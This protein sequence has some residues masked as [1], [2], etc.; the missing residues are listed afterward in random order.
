[1]KR[2][3][4]LALFLAITA[5][6]AGGMLSV[7]DNLTK[8]KI[9]E[10]SLAKELIYLEEIFP[11]AEFEQKTGDVAGV[12]GIL[13]LFEAKGEGFVYKVKSNGYGGGI[14]FLVGF[15][16]DQKIA[17]L[18]IISHG[19]TPGIGDVITTDGYKE[20]NVGKGGG[21]ALDTSTGATISSNAINKGIQAAATHL[22]GGELEI[23][24]AEVEFGDKVNLNFEK[25]ERYK[26]EILNKEVDGDNT[27]YEVKAEGYGLKD[28]EYPSPDYKEN[29]FKITVKTDSKEIVSIEMTEFGDTEGLGDTVNNPNYFKEFVGKSSLEDEYDTVSGATKTSYSLLA[30]LKAVMEDQ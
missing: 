23:E 6:L 9:A 22:A 25:L 18:A 15:D 5:G 8:D 20:L 26:T 14:V 4:Y 21:D 29:I 27:V 19:E 12:D 3:L 24:A 1:M 7:V 13:D 28:A 30:A 17:G 2:A 16:N 11:G 10:A